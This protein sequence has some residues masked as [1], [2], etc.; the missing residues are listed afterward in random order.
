MKPGSALR[1]LPVNPMQHN[2][3]VLALAVGA[4][5]LAAGCL[6]VVE[7]TGS[8]LVAVA[9][10]AA[11]VAAPFIMLRHRWALIG[12]TVFEGANIS[13]VANMQGIP[14]VYEFLLFLALLGIAIT[15]VRTHRAPPTS[16]AVW[17]GVAF[18]ASR[19]VSIVSAQD[20][21]ASRA[22]LV[23]TAK[24]LVFFAVIVALCAWTRGDRLVAR[25]LV[26]TVAALC[27][28]EVVQQFL[29]GNS[30]A[31]LGLSRFPTHSDV[32]LGVPRHPGPL[33]DPNFWGRVLVSVLPL[34]LGLFAGSGRARRW[35]WLVAA[36]LIG[37][38]VYLTGSRGTVIALVVAL[39][40]WCPLAGRRYGRMLLLAP[41]VAVLLLPLPGIGS[42]LGSLSDLGARTSSSRHDPSLAAR[43]AT[44]EAGLHMFLDHPAIGV[45][46]ANFGAAEVAYQRRYGVDEG[47]Y[48]PHN[49]YLQMAAESGTIGL[50]GW[51]AFY[52]CALFLAVRAR[53][54]WRLP[55]RAVG[56]AEWHLSGGVLAG[57]VG[58]GVASVFLHLA[59]FPIFLLLVAVA[60]T[61][62][63][64]A[65][66]QADPASTGGDGWQAAALPR[67]SRPRP[68]TRRRRRRQVL[69]GGTLLAA[70]IALALT[71]DVFYT[72]RYAATVDVALT[73]ASRSQAP[74]Y[75]QEVLGRKLVTDT[76]LTMLDGSRFAR[77]AER[78]L[79]VPAEV[80][81][82]ITVATSITP[83]PHVIGI[84]V[85][86]PDPTT[87]RA[88]ATH[89]RSTARA[90]VRRLDPLYVIEPMGQ[91][92]I[93]RVTVVRPDVPTLVL[94]GLAIAG[95]AAFTVEFY[96]C[97]MGEP[98]S[99]AHGRRRPR[100]GAPRALA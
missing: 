88:V 78:H 42:R 84:T 65:R 17:F 82:R 59:T 23:A 53:A 54:L 36:T 18:L 63:Q 13:G 91:A 29:L 89:A 41:A 99:A 43:R 35:W 2:G 32:G 83:H 11:L 14:H 1:C 55:G 67:R 86:A 68:A 38:G 8:P 46:D 33:A 37:L 16:I 47:A 12:L 92:R 39:A 52:G 61:L 90:Y 75:A 74:A 6:A 56:G 20:P 73:P 24:D 34:A 15:C 7:V 50:A 100:P 96:T 5:A 19:A 3:I 93:R 79:G 49:L 71:P 94:N 58:W 69:V 66:T 72:H 98:V 45:G 31:V 95:L 22:A 48:A 28:L 80:R 87:A 70:I 57:L 25:T 4:L 76:Y 9:A 21:S 60:A 40:V 26:G 51:M 64:R 10:A 77:S 62:D 30:T 85:T 44:Q 81:D 97:Q 27:L